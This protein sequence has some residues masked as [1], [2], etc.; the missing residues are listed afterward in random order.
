MWRTRRIAREVL[1]VASRR[2]SGPRTLVDCA[3][4]LAAAAASLPRASTCGIWSGR[5]G[6]RHVCREEGSLGPSRVSHRAFS[7][8][9]AGDPRGACW[10]CGGGTSRSD[11]FFCGGCGAVLPALDDEDDDASDAHLLFRVLGVDP[12]RFALT[13]DELEVAMKT[14]QKTLHPDEFSTAPTNAKTHSADQASLVNRAYATLRDPLKR[15]KYMLRAAGAGVAEESGMGDEQGAGTGQGLIDPVL[16]MEVMET[17][18]AI[19]D[20]AGDADA[21]RR[22][23]D[24]ND[25]E[26]A[27]CRE[28]LAR[29][30]DGEPMDLET[31]RRVTVKMTY[32][33]MIRTE[34][35]ERS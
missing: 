14:L 21:L 25:A 15:A 13:N 1:R 24:A 28:A 4:H 27:A 10:S 34:I 17:R 6:G 19:E 26:E 31:A 33:A 3:E 12:P 7:D 16:L 2:S 32:L 23:R 35:T 11:L 30:L 8:S 20:A 5:R 18:E 29:A 9:S 22:L